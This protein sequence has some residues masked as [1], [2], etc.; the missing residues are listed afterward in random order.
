MDL[1]NGQSVISMTEM[2]YQNEDLENGQK[3][4]FVS[5]NNFIVEDGKSVFDLTVS[6]VSIKSNYMIVPNTLKIG[7][8]TGEEIVFV[9]KEKSTQTVNRTEIPNPAKAIECYFQIDYDDLLKLLNSETILY[10]K[11]VDYKTGQEKDI[12][13]KYK[14][15]LNELMKCVM[16]L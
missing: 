15:Q 8:E 4:F 7:L 10:L 12:T 5:A 6:Y 11:V 13:P 16:N 2:F 9:A 14:G 1:D 3:A